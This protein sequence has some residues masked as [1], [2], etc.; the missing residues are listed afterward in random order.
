MEDIY[1]SFI[2]PVQFFRFL[3]GRCHG[4]QFCIASKTQ[5]I[6]DFLQFLHHYESVLGAD[7]MP[8]ETDS[9]V[10]N[11]PCIRWGTYGCNQANTIERSVLGV[12]ARYRYCYCTKFTWIMLLFKHVLIAFYRFRKYFSYLDSLST[13]VHALW[14]FIRNINVL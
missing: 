7:E 1:V 12:H 8:F 11:E 4:N 9:H 14:K 10:L 13:V 2:D 5:T 6:C 3:K